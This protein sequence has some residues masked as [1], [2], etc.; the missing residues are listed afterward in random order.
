MDVV[1][2]LAWVRIVLKEQ[3]ARPEYGWGQAY[4]EEEERSLLLGML[5][6]VNRPCRG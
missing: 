6:I 2:R 5:R 1:W 4:V 3:A